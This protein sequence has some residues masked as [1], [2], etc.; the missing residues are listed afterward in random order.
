MSLIAVSIFLAGKGC[1]PHSSSLMNNPRYCT[2]GGPVI[3]LPACMYRA[4][5]GSGATSAHH[6][7]GETP[8]NLDSSSKPYAVPRRSLPNITS[9]CCTDLNGCSTTCMQKVSHLPFME[10]VVIL[11][12]VAKASINRDLPIVPAMITKLS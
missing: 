5:W 2:D 8:S 9:A 4:A 12:V 11:P 10:A 1:S 6:V 7:N 3:F